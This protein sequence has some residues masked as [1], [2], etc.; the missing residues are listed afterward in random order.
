MVLGV[1]IDEEMIDKDDVNGLTGTS[2][3][4][5]VIGPLHTETEWGL[6]ST[7]D[8]EL[9]ALNTVT[10]SGTVTGTFTVRIYVCHTYVIVTIP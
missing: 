7:C 1:N 10:M 3:G 9:D 6:L 8:M 5:L 4:R 2:L